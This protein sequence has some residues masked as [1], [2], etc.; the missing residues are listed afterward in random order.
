MNSITFFY[1]GAYVSK[2]KGFVK[3]IMR[4]LFFFLAAANVYLFLVKGAR[5]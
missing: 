5:L 1:C 3:K 4:G 2:G